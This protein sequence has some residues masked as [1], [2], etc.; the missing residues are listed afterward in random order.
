MRNKNMTLTI[1]ITAFL[2]IFIIS[3]IYVL[4]CYSYYDG[5]QKEKY[6]DEFKKRDYDFVYERLTDKDKINREEFN[7]VIDLMYNQNTLENIYNTYYKDSNLYS[8]SE[9]F[10][11][12]FYYG[13]KKITLDDIEF[14]KEGK[15]NLFKRSK[16]YYKKVNVNNGVNNSA[17]GIID[18]VTFNIERNSTLRIDNKLLN[19]DDDKCVVDYMF[20]GLH[21]VNYISNNYTYYGI[22]NVTSNV[23]DINITVL[24]SLI[25]VK[26]NLE[27]GVDVFKDQNIINNS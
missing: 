15:S 10:I 17:I 27:T 19:C 12:E 18:N 5:Y 22:V 7:K 13:N 21:E 6:L 20:M 4:Y 1:G 8:N 14:M 9:E 23:R 25:N 26:L 16:F 3:L 2:F 11:K 24:D